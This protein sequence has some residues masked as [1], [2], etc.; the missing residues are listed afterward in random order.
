MRVV[1][2]SE[3]AHRVGLAELVEPVAA[4]LVAYSEGRVRTAPMMLF[5]LP[6][7]EVHVKAA[8]MDGAP[9]WSV[10]VSASVPRNTVRGLTAAQST[11][12]LFDAET[13]R[14]SV[15]IT[16]QG[17]LLTGLRTAAAGGLA[18]RML[19]P[20]T[21]TL[22]VLG[23]G[24][25][26]RLQPQAFW[27]ERPYRR[28]LVWGRNCTA[29]EKVVEDLRLA[30]PEVEVET[31]ADLPAAVGQAQ[32]VVTASTS[33]RPLLLGEWLQRGQHVTAIGA[34]VVGKR[35]L[36]DDA[37]ARADRLYVDSL[38]QNLQVGEVAAAVANGA[39]SLADVTG[40]LGALLRQPRVREQHELTVAKL[41]GIG[42]QDLAAAL[43]VLDNVGLE[44]PAS[45]HIPQVTYDAHVRTERG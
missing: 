28:L 37:L 32:S 35:E 22:L 17:G 19:A 1:T 20:E 24:L 13:G 12:T 18:A 39:L 7:G 10:K 31:A 4:S 6:D 38:A 29:A 26:A 21:D 34:D 45:T 5:D 3:V 41:V 11:V 43:T 9:Y 15:L 44:E 33:N 30:L 14:P 40:E 23:T 16:D 36:D 42:V 2:F 8:V 27:R 25:Q